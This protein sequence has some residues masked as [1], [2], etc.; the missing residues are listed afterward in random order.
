[1]NAKQFLVLDHIA[2]VEDGAGNKDGHAPEVT[3]D[4]AA[5][6]AQPNKP[7]KKPA[8]DNTT[9]YL[10]IT[11]A[12][13]VIGGAAMVMTEPDQNAS[14]D[15]S[16]ESAE[17][18]SLSLPQ[19]SQ[20]DRRD[21]LDHVD[22]PSHEQTGEQTDEE[23][24]ISGSM[25]FSDT[26]APEPEKVAKVTKS[27]GYTCSLIDNSRI[28]DVYLNGFVQNEGIFTYAKDYAQVRPQMIFALRPFVQGYLDGEMTDFAY[29]KS[30]S[31]Y[32]SRYQLELYYKCTGTT[33]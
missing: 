25:G 21:A 10:L 31:M 3:Q 7:K 19:D 18:T 29:L 8:I 16:Q 6:P 33:R 9:K 30:A 5:V 12:A 20:D 17:L 1:M 11:I 27:R 32:L 22:V 4:E 13:L 2:N 24:E 28:N 23:Q 26:P 14:G 15:Q